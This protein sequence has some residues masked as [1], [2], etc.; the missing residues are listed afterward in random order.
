MKMPHVPM[1]SQ[2]LMGNTTEGTERIYGTYHPLF[3]MTLVLMISK[4]TKNLTKTQ[5]AN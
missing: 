4:M 1:I 3:I 2:D 5:V